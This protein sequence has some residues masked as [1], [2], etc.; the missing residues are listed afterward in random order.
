MW[1]HVESALKTDFKNKKIAVLAYIFKTMRPIDCVELK[2]WFGRAII[3]SLRVDHAEEVDI[4]N[5]VSNL[6]DT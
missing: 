6:C 5:A 2:G 3:E 1:W 4:N